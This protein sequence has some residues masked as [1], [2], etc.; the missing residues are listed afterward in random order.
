MHKFFHPRL[1][2]GDLL[3]LGILWS[4]DHSYL[5]NA[6]GEVTLPEK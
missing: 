1:L 4:S 6:C 3:F 2:V 5:Q